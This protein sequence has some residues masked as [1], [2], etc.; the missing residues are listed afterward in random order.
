MSTHMRGH[1]VYHTSSIRDGL[2]LKHLSLVTTKLIATSIISSILARVSIVISGTLK[3]VSLIISS[4]LS[5]SIAYILRYIEPMVLFKTI[6]WMNNNHLSIDA[7]NFTFIIST[8]I[9]IPRF[10]SSSYPST[11][12]TTS[13]PVSYF[14]YTTS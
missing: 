1:R 12:S 9:R 14:N 7:Y 4:H 6:R 5:Q 11:A 13:Y 10:N 2:I 3:F 8:G